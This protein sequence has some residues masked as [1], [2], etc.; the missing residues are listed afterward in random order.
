[1]E[2]C[3]IKDKELP[4]EFW[5]QAV[6]TSIYLQ[7]RS[8]TKAVKGKTPLQAWC[9]HNSFV[10][11]LKVFGSICYIHV[12]FA[13][14]H[15][16]DSKAEKGIFVGHGSQSKGYRVY[17]LQTKEVNVSRDIVFDEEACWN[18]DE[19]KQEPT[20]TIFPSFNHNE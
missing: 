19:D 10:K 4:N 14:R 5:A 12:P 18:R 16:L 7:K 15:R 20:N 1:M 17:N 11:H 13:K 3:L 8:V 6:Y 9:G 2:R